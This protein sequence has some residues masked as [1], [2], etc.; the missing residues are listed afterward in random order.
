LDNNPWQK[1]ETLSEKE[2]YQKGLE[3]MA[4]VAALGPEFKIYKVC[5]TNILI[6]FFSYIRYDGEMTL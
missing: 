3:G 4:Q 5:K 2:P 1:H 6:K